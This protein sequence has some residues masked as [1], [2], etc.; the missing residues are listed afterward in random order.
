MD[1][2][3]DE[4]RRSSRV[5]TRELPRRYKSLFYNVDGE[6]HLSNKFEKLHDSPNVY[7]VKDFLTQGELDFLDR[8]VTAFQKTF[9][10]SFTEGEDCS[11]LVS[12]ERT[13]TFIHIEKGKNA[14]IRR[15]E[16]KAAELIGM[17]GEFVEPLQIVSYT[18]GQKFELHHDAGTL[19]DDGTVELVPPH[20]SVHSLH[21]LLSKAPRR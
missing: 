5:P 4:P 17:T 14:A 16:S 8:H 2:T 18:Q 11:K 19:G 7:L 1:A 21:T 9:K 20:R 3:V 15:I 13:S 12:E 10:A 6:P